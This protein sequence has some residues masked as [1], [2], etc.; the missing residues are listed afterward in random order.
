MH[1]ATFAARVLALLEE[2]SMPTE[3]ARRPRIT[4]AECGQARPHEAKGLCATCYN[5][6]RRSTQPARSHARNEVTRGLR[7]V[8]A[9]ARCPGCPDVPRCPRAVLPGTGYCLRC[10]PLAR[11]AA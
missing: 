2:G 1:N 9:Q 5:R 3:H 4:C 10:G 11:V 6:G 7:P 8:P